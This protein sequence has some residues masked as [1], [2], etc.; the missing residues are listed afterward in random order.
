MLQNIYAYGAVN[1]DFC[2]YPRLSATRA[3]AEDLPIPGGPGYK[4]MYNT[5]RTNHINNYITYIN[6]IFYTE[7]KQINK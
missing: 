1:N 4:C 7:N 5:I 2:V 3:A 6:Y